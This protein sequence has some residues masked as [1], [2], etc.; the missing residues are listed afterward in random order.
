MLPIPE[1]SVEP[2]P[3]MSPLN[4]ASPATVSAIPAVDVMVNVLSDWSVPVRSTLPEEMLVR[5]EPS[6]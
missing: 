2:S 4:C 6:P 1:I 5:P 3:R